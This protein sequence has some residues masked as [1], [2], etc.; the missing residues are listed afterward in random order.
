MHMYSL[1]GYYQMLGDSFSWSTLSE[2]DFTEVI[3]SKVSF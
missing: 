3:F 2:S 1:I